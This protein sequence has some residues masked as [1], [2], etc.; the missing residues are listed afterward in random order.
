MTTDYEMIRELIGNFNQS[1]QR[2]DKLTILKDLEY[3]VHQ[4]RLSEL[5]C[6]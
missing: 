5:L 2:A 1:E 6:D 4:V 3:Y